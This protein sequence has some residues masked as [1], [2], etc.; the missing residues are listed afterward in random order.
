MPTYFSTVE[1]DMETTTTPSM[2][3][4]CPFP[5]PTATLVQLRAVRGL[6]AHHREQGEA[7]H[8]QVNDK[9]PRT[10]G[11]CFIHVSELDAIV[12]ISEDI[13]VSPMPP[14]GPV[15]RKI[16]QTIADMVPDGATIQAGI[17]PSCR[18]RLWRR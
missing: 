10:L 14:I 18:T 8:C 7:G 2:S 15:E 5:A 4:C 1:R 17:G 3:P 11:E 16:G 13:A 12:E 9:M 6:P